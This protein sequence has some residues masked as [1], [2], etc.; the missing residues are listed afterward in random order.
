MCIFIL[1]Y[2][3]QHD[4][5]YTMLAYKPQTKRIRESSGEVT[6]HQQKYY[7][8]YLVGSRIIQERLETKITFNHR[9]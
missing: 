6:I 1:I 3:W 4:R 7:N 5:I 8:K 2:T 9:I